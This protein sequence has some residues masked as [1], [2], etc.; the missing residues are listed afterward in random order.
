MSSGERAKISPWRK[1]KSGSEPDDEMITLWQLVPNCE[2]SLAGP[3]DELLG[4]GPR[5]THR[6][7]LARVLR[8]QLVVDRSREDGRHLRER[9]LAIGRCEIGHG[10]VRAPSPRAMPSPRASPSRWLRSCGSRM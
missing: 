4:V 3:R 2:H 1:P 7:S 8:D 10:Q 5:T 6:S 9:D